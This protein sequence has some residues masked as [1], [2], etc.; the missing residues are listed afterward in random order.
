[1]RRYPGYTLSVL[2]DE[3]AHELHQ[4]IGLLRPD[5]GKLKDDDGE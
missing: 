5:L 4:H 3:D 2:L 1:M